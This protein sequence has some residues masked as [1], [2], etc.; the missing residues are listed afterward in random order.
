MILSTRL[1]WDGE[2]ILRPLI[3]L[4]LDPHRC[5]TCDDYYPDA[6]PKWRETLPICRHCMEQVRC[7]SAG[8]EGHRTCGVCEACQL[9]RLVCQHLGGGEA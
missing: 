9:P 7:P 6:L 4:D 1:E 8:D 2:A 5:V 3:D